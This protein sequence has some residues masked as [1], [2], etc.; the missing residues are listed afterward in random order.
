MKKTLFIMFAAA[1]MVACNNQQNP[2]HGEA[3]HQCGEECMNMNSSNPPHG[4]VGHKCTEN[5]MKMANDTSN[6]NMPTNQNMEMK[7]HI[8]SDACKEEKHLYAHGEKE[9]QCNEECMKMNQKK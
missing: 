5:C 7:E 9:H 3:G 4:E 8:C 6:N 1:A 2:T